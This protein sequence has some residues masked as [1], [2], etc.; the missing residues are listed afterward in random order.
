MD[1]F[2]TEGSH[3]RERVQR[4][5]YD[6]AGCFWPD[7]SGRPAVRQIADPSKTALVHKC[8]Y[9]RTPQACMLD[10]YLRREVFLKAASA[11]GSFWGWLGRGATLRQ[12]AL[13]SSR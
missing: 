8:H 2:T 1:E 7:G 3:G 12:P 5:A 11:A 9:G 6:L 13:A 10:G 4:F